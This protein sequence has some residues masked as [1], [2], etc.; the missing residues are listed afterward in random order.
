MRKQPLGQIHKAVAKTEVFSV[1]LSTGVASASLDCWMETLVSN[2]GQTGSDH[3]KQIYTAQWMAQSY[4]SYMVSV[5]A[6]CLLFDSQ[7]VCLFVGVC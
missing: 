2:D 6:I 4:I 7:F 5:C 1:F 3:M